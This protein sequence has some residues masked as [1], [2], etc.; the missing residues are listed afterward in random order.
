MSEERKDDD[1]DRENGEDEENKCEFSTRRPKRVNA[2][3][4]NYFRQ[5]SAAFENGEEDEEGMELLVENAI[6]EMSGN[7]ASM[8]SH[9]MCSYVVEMLLRAASDD[10][11]LRIADSFTGFYLHLFT[12]RYA[13]HVIESLFAR[14]ADILSGK[15]HQIKEKVSDVHVRQICE[16]VQSSWIPI[17]SDPSGCHCLRA[18]VN[19]LIGR[20]M[21]KK[22]SAS[23]RKK[24]R[25]KNKNKETTTSEVDSALSEPIFTP[26]NR[27]DTYLRRFWR[28]CIAVLRAAIRLRSRPCVSAEA[29]AEPCNM[30]S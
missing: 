1:V 26:R 16:E 8:A 12:N 15:S 28:V 9:K 22:Q 3:T 23:K 24:K 29:A 27:S 4:V 2:D 11:L 30:F 18:L 13:S 14:F 7:E 20:A 17:L 25:K 6:E 10:Q 21:Q 5:I 19:L